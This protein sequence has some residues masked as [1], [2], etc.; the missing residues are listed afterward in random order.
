[1]IITDTTPEGTIPLEYPPITVLEQS[2]RD[3][4]ALRQIRPNF[5][6]NTITDDQYDLIHG[7]EWYLLMDGHWTQ[8]MTIGA[9]IYKHL[10]RKELF[11]FC[12]H[13]Y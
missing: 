2:R 5:V 3:A 10:L 13:R 6:G 12:Q 11:L 4:M 9:L 7:F 8:T 1:M